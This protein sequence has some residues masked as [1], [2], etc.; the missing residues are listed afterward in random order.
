M[1][2]YVVAGGVAIVGSVLWWRNAS[3]TKPET[4]DYKN[5]KIVVDRARDMG[6]KVQHFGGWTGTFQIGTF[7]NTP[8]GTAEFVGKQGTVQAPTRAGAVAMAEAAIDKGGVV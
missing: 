2:G 6:G 3:A 7:V 1:I 5:A 8:Q 4:V